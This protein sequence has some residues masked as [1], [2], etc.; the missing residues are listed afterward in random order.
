MWRSKSKGGYWNGLV[1]LYTGAVNP[2]TPLSMRQYRG[3]A[4]RRLL[5]CGLILSVF[6]VNKGRSRFARVMWKRFGALEAF[7]DLALFGQYA[8]RKEL[9]DLI[10][11][12]DPVAFGLAAALGETRARKLVDIVEVIPFGERFG[13]SFHEMSGPISAFAR[14]EALWAAR[15][16]DFRIF[17]MDS[18][19]T[20]VMPRIGDGLTIQNK[21]THFVNE[22]AKLKLP[23]TSGGIRLA[24]ANRQTPESMAIDLILAADAYQGTIEFLI[25][26]PVSPRDYREDLERIAAQR[27]WV[28]LLPVVPHDQLIAEL[29]Q[30]DV[31]ISAFTGVT[32]N[33]RH[34]TPN[35]LFD[36]IAAGLPVVTTRS[37]DSGRIVDEY[38]NGAVVEPHAQQVFEAARDI[39]ARCRQPSMIDACQRA[40]DGLVWGEQE[41]QLDAMIGKAERI[42]V[43]APKNPVRGIR[44]RKL[45]NHFRAGGAD[46][47]TLESHFEVAVTPAGDIGAGHRLD[48]NTT[49]LG[50][51]AIRAHPLWML[52]CMRDL[53]FM[54]LNPV[55][56]L[57]RLAQR[58]AQ[59]NGQA[60]ADYH[61]IESLLL[62][63][64]TQSSIQT[65]AR[66]K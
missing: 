20:E 1:P 22:N 19:R 17:A 15:R 38:G 44:L 43:V 53:L 24:I 2:D 60:T 66:Q 47:D 63:I 7:F 27:P 11:F 57:E 36:Y 25:G 65:R 56:Y 23:R 51:A 48:R 49:V 32:G 26:G 45:I 14:Q 41:A 18:Y 37:G 12:H 3:R 59:A 39:A 28:S 13:A 16:A 61:D 42:L 21:H 46:V 5:A 8:C 6:R 30:C 10:V 35:R 40:A 62:Q 55:R 31:G 9:Y 34:A 58:L 64:K 29:R 4:L 52:M 50:S 33:G 54:A